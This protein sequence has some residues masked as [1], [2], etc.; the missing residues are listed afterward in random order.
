MNVRLYINNYENAA[1]SS[2]ANRS[3]TLAPL[4]RLSREKSS[5]RI[6][7]DIFFSYTTIPLPN[8]TEELF[9]R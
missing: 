1:L 6:I 4:D 8:L 2:V 3:T 7:L 5:Q 9:V